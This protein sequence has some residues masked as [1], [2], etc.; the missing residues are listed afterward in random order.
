[1]AKETLKEPTLAPYT[2][3]LRSGAVVGFPDQ[4]EAERF[5]EGLT[6][7]MPW[8]PK[9][10]EREGALGGGFYALLD[11]VGEMTEPQL[12]AARNFALA[13]IMCL[14]GM[15]KPR[16]HFDDQLFAYYLITRATPT[17]VTT[18][19]TKR[20]TMHVPSATFI[21]ALCGSC[22]QRVWEE[23]QAVSVIQLNRD[24]GNFATLAVHRGVMDFGPITRCDDCG[25]ITRDEHTRRMQA[26]IG[27]KPPT[28]VRTTEEAFGEED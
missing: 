25:S 3:T 5:A 22:A 1:M 8:R 23:T 24:H 10:E 21:R 9:V 20:A 14:G 28:Q 12:T 2:E 19:A 4:A 27:S 6:K 13:W 26:Q 18:L 16:A 17:D 15:M 7:I 11:R